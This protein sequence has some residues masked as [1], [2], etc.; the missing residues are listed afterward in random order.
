[1][2][3]VPLQ[4]LHAGMGDSADLG[5]AEARQADSTLNTIE[6]GCKTLTVMDIPKVNE[7]VSHVARTLKVHRQVQKI[8]G[9]SKT[10]I[11]LL[12]KHRPRVVDRD[13][14]EHHR[15]TALRVV[16][17]VLRFATGFEVGLRLGGSTGHFDLAACDR[18]GL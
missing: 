9:T 12:E 8:E 1:M 10:A 5:T 17:C 6:L 14:A 7:C 3:D 13:V 16:F 4:S 2:S 15:G 11:E 18:H